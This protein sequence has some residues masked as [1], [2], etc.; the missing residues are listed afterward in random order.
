MIPSKASK[1][2]NYD[3][4]NCAKI[5]KQSNMMYIIRTLLKQHRS[6]PIPLIMYFHL[7]SYFAQTNNANEGGYHGSLIIFLLP[8]T[9]IHNPLL[10]CNP[11]TTTN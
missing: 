9:I 4:K 6:L 7:S 8:F 10:G 3:E 11:T 2:S 1:I 5:H